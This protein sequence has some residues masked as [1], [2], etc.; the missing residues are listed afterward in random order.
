MA[1]LLY[2]IA[3]DYTD[4]PNKVASKWMFMVVVINMQNTTS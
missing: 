4:K 2:W 1:E 3:L